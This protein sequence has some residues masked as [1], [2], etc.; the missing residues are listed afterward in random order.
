MALL[1]GLSVL[2]AVPAQAQMTVYSSG[3]VPISSTR[4]LTAYVPLAVPTVRWAVNG[5]L[6]GDAT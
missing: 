1:L 2:A 4:Q 5:T 3:P 6:G